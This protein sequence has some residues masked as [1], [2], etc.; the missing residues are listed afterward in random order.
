MAVAS[1]QAALLRTQLQ[2]FALSKSSTCLTLRDTELIESKHFDLASAPPL[3]R[4]R[5]KAKELSL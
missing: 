1:C 4:Q 5:L 2:G 3:P